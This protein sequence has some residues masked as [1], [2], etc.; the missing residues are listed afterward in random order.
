MNDTSTT[1]RFLDTIDVA[2]PCSAPWSD[3][4]GDER[5]RHCEQC[6]LNVYNLSE[7]S[8]RQATALVEKTEGRLCVRFLRRADGTVLTKDCP[9]GI[10]ALKRRA[11]LAYARVAALLGVVCSGLF[12]CGPR[13]NTTGDPAVDPA[14]AHG[15]TLPGQAVMGEAVMGDVICPAPPAA[16]MGK[17]IMAPP[18]TTQPAPRMVTPVEKLRTKPEDSGR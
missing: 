18:A 14:R 12:G 1:D 6:K 2:T 5:V 8:E 4:T 10:T 16:T 13:G 17:M 15:T 11:R 3:M 7:M 9:V